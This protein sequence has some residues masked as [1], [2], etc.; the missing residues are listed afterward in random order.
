MDAAL[1]SQPMELQGENR[2]LKKM[3]ANA[4]PS[5]ELLE[6]AMAKNGEA[7]SWETTR[8][9]VEGGRTSIRHACQTF[10]L[11]ETGYS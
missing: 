2:R 9:A 3:G 11:G 4:Q 6:E 8:W 5:A 1:M 10:A 7:I